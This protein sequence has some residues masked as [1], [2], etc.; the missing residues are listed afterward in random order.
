[1]DGKIRG[2]S[3]GIVPQPPTNGN[4]SYTGKVM[5]SS[6]WLVAACCQPFYC[7]LSMFKFIFF[8]FM[9]FRH[10]PFFFCFERIYLSCFLFSQQKIPARVYLCARFC[11]REGDQKCQSHGR[12]TH[13]SFRMVHAFLQP[14]FWRHHFIFRQRKC[15][16]AIK[17]CDSHKNKNDR[18]NF[19]DAHKM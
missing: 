10:Q 2:Q 5:L 8:C 6:A 12:Q 11:S 18:P 3:S 15:T 17:M 14:H 16:M 7:M 13:I 19:D 4:K 1:M 9:F